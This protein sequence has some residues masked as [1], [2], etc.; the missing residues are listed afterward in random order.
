[1]CQSVCLCAWLLAKSLRVMPVVCVPEQL[2]VHVA[3]KLGATC[4]QAF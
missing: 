2:L 3:I 4:A 1:M